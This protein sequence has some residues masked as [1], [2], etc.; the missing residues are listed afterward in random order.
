[1]QAL[2]HTV[3]SRCSRRLLKYLPSAIALLTRQCY[4]YHM[5]TKTDKLYQLTA[6]LCARLVL[7]RNVACEP[8]RCARDWYC[9]ANLLQGKQ[10]VAR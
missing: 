6:A 8:L 5:H 9:L 3:T 7:P 1:M 2:L 10:L 4:Y